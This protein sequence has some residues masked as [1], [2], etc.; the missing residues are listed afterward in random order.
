MVPAI[1]GYRYGQVL[2][3]NRQKTILV[4][5]GLLQQLFPFLGGIRMFILAVSLQ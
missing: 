3:K 1:G 4:S 5:D 2:K